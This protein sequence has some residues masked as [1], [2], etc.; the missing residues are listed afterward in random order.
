MFDHVTIRVSDREAS[1]LFY[2]QLLAVLGVAKT[3]SDEWDDFSL[4]Q[5][6]PVTRRLHIGF[7]APSRAEVDEFWRRGTAAGYRDDGPPGPRPQYGDDYY[8][9]FLRDPDGNSAEAV[10]HGT[11]RQGGVIDHVW[12]RVADVAA[13]RRFYEVAAPFAGMRV[14]EARD[15]YVR[16]A[17]PTGSFSLLAGP[18]TEH[19]HMALPAP[20]DET[21]EAFH[22]AAVAAGY[23]DNGP[24]GERSVYHPGYFG[25]YV[26]DPD[27][28]NFEL[29][30]H[31]R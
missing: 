30:N 21:V 6:E 15:D 25:A 4:A 11:L 13:S 5:G 8:G 14:A 23:R 12:I 3:Q 20:D 10:H 26:L 16:F 24:P 18:P 2:D 19:L 28:H 27:G 9:S 31:N 17:G 29:V 7:V 1:E 22:S